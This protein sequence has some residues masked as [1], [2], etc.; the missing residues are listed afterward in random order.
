M[1]HYLS[2]CVSFCLIAARQISKHMPAEIN[3]CRLPDIVFAHECAHTT[4]HHLHNLDSL[5]FGA[6][7]NEVT[8]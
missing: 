3:A 8:A 5:C 1:S 6:V 7:S 2:P 4:L